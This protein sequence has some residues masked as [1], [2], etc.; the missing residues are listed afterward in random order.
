MTIDRVLWSVATVCAMVGIALRVIPAATPTPARAVVPAP[1]SPPAVP[2]VATGAAVVDANIFA[3]NR[4]APRLRF[5]ARAGAARSPSSAPVGPELTLYGITVTAEG[6]FALIDSD[7][8]VAGAEI[9]RVGDLV[10]GARLTAIT[11]STVTLTPRSGGPARVLRLPAAP[12][13]RRLL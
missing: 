5:S 13:L 12:D 9:Y 10:R 4:T 11:D 2:P 7:P 8:Q 3:S 1:V 6:A